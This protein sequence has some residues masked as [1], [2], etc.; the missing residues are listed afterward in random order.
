MA[1]RRG[2]YA[3]WVLALVLVKAVSHHE[4]TVAGADDVLGQAIVVPTSSVR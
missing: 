4:A 3:R 1:R 2:R